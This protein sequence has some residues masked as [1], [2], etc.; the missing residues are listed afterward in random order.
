MSIVFPTNWVP[1]QNSELYGKEDFKQ[2]MK[3]D[4]EMIARRGREEELWLG[5][6]SKGLEFRYI[7]GLI[8]SFNNSQITESIGRVGG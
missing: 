3:I 2:E 5:I 7:H 1:V 8:I 4:E 6:D